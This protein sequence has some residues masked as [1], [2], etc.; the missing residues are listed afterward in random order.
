MVS[1]V[2]PY[3]YDAINTEDTITNRLYVIQ[4]ISE[5]YTIQNNTTIDGQ[6][7]SYGELVVNTQYL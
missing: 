6:V 1:L 3:M 7:I 5:A 4:F 2:Q